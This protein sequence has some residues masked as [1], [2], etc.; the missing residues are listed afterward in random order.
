MRTLAQDPG[1]HTGFAEYVSET[2]FHRAWYLKAGEAMAWLGR[3]LAE[4]PPDEVVSESIR[5]N[6]QTHKKSQDV[7][8]SVEQIGIARYLCHAHGIPFVTQTPT[9][10]K[11]FA[12]DD[13]LRAYGW[14]TKG[15]TDHPRDA[16][17]HLMTRVCK[18]D[19]AFAE[20]LAGRL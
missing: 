10:A 13:K 15:P 17:R 4:N 16:S 14:W 7:L 20:A 5:I 6:A 19:A 2:G 18:T 12:S 9:E 3:E 1:G 8:I 11:R